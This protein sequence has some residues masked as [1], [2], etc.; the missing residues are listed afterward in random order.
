MGWIE[1]KNLH[2]DASTT[3]ITDHL[4]RLAQEVVRQGWAAVPRYEG[5]CPLLR[6]FDPAVP[7][8]GE[9]IMLVPGAAPDLWRYRSSA[10]EDLGPHTDPARAA[11]QVTRILTPFVTA[12]RGAWARRTPRGATAA[13]RTVSSRT[14]VGCT[15]PG[16]TAPS[17]AVPG[18]TGPSTAG[19]P[20]RPV[21]P[22]PPP[23]PDPSRTRTIADLHARFGVICWWGAHT[24]E[25]WALVPGAARWRLVSA[26]ASEELAETIIAVHAVSQ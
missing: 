22:A 8:F 16:R 26:T 23:D 20:A 9:S 5:P 14:V 15:A 3:S 1:P 2:T 7:G 12:A 17:H 10:G 4:D 13:G 24:K 19:R 6:V 25:W 11:G 18:H 21:L